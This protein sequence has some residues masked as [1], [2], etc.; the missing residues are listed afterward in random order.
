VVYID[1]RFL[2]MKHECLMSILSTGMVP[3]ALYQKIQSRGLN[4]ITGPELV[5]ESYA[6]GC[7]HRP[8]N[9]IVSPSI[10]IKLAM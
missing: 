3:L 7:S 10:S 4:Q 5:L 2:N 6:L 1:F 8:S 9:D